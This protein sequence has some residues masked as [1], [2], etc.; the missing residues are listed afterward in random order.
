MVH[1]KNVEIL[2]KVA[3]EGKAAALGRM[4]DLEEKIA[5]SYVKN[6]LVLLHIVAD[7]PKAYHIAYMLPYDSPFLE[8]INKV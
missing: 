2:S 8:S 3:Y 5:T 1:D 6:N 7:C 4:N